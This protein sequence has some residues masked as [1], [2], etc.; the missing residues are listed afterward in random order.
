[1]DYVTNFPIT[2]ITKPQ[3]TMQSAADATSHLFFAYL[4]SLTMDS[5]KGL[6]G[7]SQLPMSLQKLLKETDYPPESLKNM[8]TTTPRVL[9]IVESVSPTPFALLRRA[10][11]F[12][13]RD[14]DKALMEF[15]EYIDPIEALTDE[16]KRVLQLIASSNQSPSTHPDHF[17]GTTDTSWS[18]FEDL[19]FSCV[20][21]EKEENELSFTKRYPHLSEKTIM[22]KNSM[23]R[24]TTPSWAEFLSSGFVDELK[25]MPSPLALPP[26]LS[27]PPI[28][29]LG[30]NSISHVTTTK[31]SQLEPGELASIAKFYLDDSF[32]WVWICSLASEE[33]PQRKAAFGRC[34]LIET[35]I[36]SGKW[37]LIEEKVKGAVSSPI[38]GAY[39]AEKKGFWG[40]SKRSRGKTSRK[41][42]GKLANEGNNSL[43]PQNSTFS[44]T[45]LGSDTH[46]RIQAAA[47][48]LHEQEMKETQLLSPRA[49]WFDD[50]I[51]MKTSSVFTLQPMIMM[52]A[53]PAMNWARKYD[54]N[55]LREENSTDMNSRRSSGDPLS[56]N[57]LAPSSSRFE[58][59]SHG[60]QPVSPIALH[61]PQSSMHLQI[62]PNTSRFSTTPKFTK[63]QTN[64]SVQSSGTSTQ[65]YRIETDQANTQSTEAIPT[66][67]KASKNQTTFA[68]KSSKKSSSGSGIKR[69]FS[70]NKA[71]DTKVGVAPP[72]VT[73]G[74]EALE[75]KK[76]GSSIVRS[77]SALRKKSIT[78]SGKPSS[79][80]SISPTS[81][82]PDFKSAQNS[83]REPVKSRSGPESEFDNL[84][85]VSTSEVQKAQIVFSSFDQGPIED[86]QAPSSFQ[87]EDIDESVVS[88]VSSLTQNSVDENE[89]PPSEM[90]SEIN[91]SILK[92][93]S[94]EL[95]QDQTQS[96]ASSLSDTSD[97]ET[98]EEETIKTRVAKIKARVAQLT[99]NT[100][101]NIKPALGPSAEI[102]H[103]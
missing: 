23:G 88:A 12:Q 102:L 28:E 62:S 93:V 94:K 74:R 53:S 3:L 92:K 21:D 47:A 56:K 19:G 51:S 58:T 7:I 96:E 39:I 67:S 71:H 5:A 66:D 32:W 85:R 11:H 45:S 36:P 8:H 13:Y 41:S 69:L 2:I 100:E 15:S 63:Y 27:L 16:C 60:S 35:V 14:E 95:G 82:T 101:T 86:S 70:R 46:A 44:K 64:P 54:T 4:R 25:S 84:S 72:Q 78:P 81:P 1:M 42:P 61:S 37:L 6:A 17:G 34:T 83:P 22:S 79:T 52:E 73:N 65:E 75:R 89:I 30:Q 29:A 90:S 77:L 31:E 49:A 103:S 9:M 98:N 43:S 57:K 10:N 55:G 59:R 20:F 18:R 91:K 50:V 80:V 38:E 68:G 26:D 76:T 24:P 97:V 87:V 33:T 48:R 40:R 99:G